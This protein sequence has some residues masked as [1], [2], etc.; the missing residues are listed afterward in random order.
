MFYSRSKK[1]IKLNHLPHNLLE[2]TN[3]LAEFK[4]NKKMTKNQ[5]EMQ[6]VPPMMKILIIWMIKTKSQMMM[7]HLI[8]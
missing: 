5:K 4:K 7:N 1:P 8:T 2:E 6:I 3:I